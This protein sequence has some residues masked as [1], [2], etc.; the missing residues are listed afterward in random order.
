MLGNRWSF[1]SISHYWG[2][3]ITGNTHNMVK[4]CVKGM[5]VGSFF[6]F[7]NNF[8]RWRKR[9]SVNFLCCACLCSNLSAG[10]DS[11]RII[12]CLRVGLI[13]LQHPEGGGEYITVT[14]GWERTHCSFMNE[15]EETSQH[16]RTHSIATKET[17][18]HFQLL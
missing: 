6:Y 18:K 1:L 5:M 11:T 7:V 13:T 12:L 17:R 9:V 4:V 16:S 14:W 10:K 3:G 15:E 2:Q 8:F